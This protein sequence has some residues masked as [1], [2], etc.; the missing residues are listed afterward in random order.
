M[1]SISLAVIFLQDHSAHILGFLFAVSELLAY[2]PSVKGNGV[3][4]VVHELL[5]E[6]LRSKVQEDV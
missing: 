6:R 3:F 1:D 2:I 4:Q 5:K